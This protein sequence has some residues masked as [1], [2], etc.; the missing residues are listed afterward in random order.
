[1]VIIKLPFIINRPWTLNN[2]KKVKNKATCTIKLSIKILI[3]T[4][5]ACTVS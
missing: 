3:A 1:M 4:M 5:Y 2:T